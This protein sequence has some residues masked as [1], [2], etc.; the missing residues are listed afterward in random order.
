M[1][2]SRWV[3]AP[4]FVSIFV[5]AL[6]AQTN[7]WTVLEKLSPGT[8]ISVLTDRRQG[9]EFLDATDAELSCDRQIGRDTRLLTF[10]R[11]QVHEVRLEGNR[12]SR[13]F[14]GTMTGAMIGAAIGAS[15]GY[16]FS[17]RS[18]DA[19]TR[20][21]SPVIGFVAGGA[22]GAGIGTGIGERTEQCGKPHGTVVYRQ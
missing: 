22:M 4:V 1:V 6:N 3:T 21:Y 5:L 2:F 12:H 13:K 14:L 7:D 17:A 15:L 10:G 20:V 16:A 11:A 19:E 18:S 8:C 9:C